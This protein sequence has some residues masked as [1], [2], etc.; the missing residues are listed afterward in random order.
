VSLSDFL[1]AGGSDAASPALAAAAPPSHAWPPLSPTSLDSAFDEALR[2]QAAAAAPPPTPPPVPPT[3]PPT[4]TPAN[5]A[6][7]A[8]SSSPALS[9]AAAETG[10]A[11]GAGARAPAHIPWPSPEAVAPPA[12]AP[13][14]SA[15][16]PLT[17]T[18]APAAAAAAASGPLGALK[19]LVSRGVSGVGLSI[20]RAPSVADEAEALGSEADK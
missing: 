17:T 18:G 9:P 16:P 14:Q 11:A 12:F 4:T 5:A 8:S 7:A 3:P 13:D 15:G 2:A 20:S 10:D 6:A 1:V 19:R